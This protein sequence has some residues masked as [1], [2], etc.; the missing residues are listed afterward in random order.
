MNDRRPDP[1]VI[2]LRPGVWTTITSKYVVVPLR[3]RAGRC[4]ADCTRLSISYYGGAFIDDE[5]GLTLS[6]DKP[7]QADRH[8]AILI[9][10]EGKVIKEI[11]DGEKVLTYE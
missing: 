6:E 11:H 10:R 4:V 1:I 9:K 8:P 2:D 7:L 3:P 5:G